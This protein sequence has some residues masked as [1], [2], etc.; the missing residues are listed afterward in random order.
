[1][2]NDINYHKKFITN[3]LDLNRE[4]KIGVHINDKNKLELDT[5]RLMPQQ[6]LNEVR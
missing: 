3:C 4:E 1:M 6:T 5:D 2:K